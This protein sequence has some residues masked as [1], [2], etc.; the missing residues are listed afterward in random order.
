MDIT[1]GTALLTAELP[2]QISEAVSTDASTP[3]NQ[4]ILDAAKDSYKVHQAAV[5]ALTTA[6]VTDVN[7]TSLTDARNAL[8]ATNWAGSGISPT[9]VTPFFSGTAM[10]TALETVRQDTSIKAA[11]VGAFTGTGPGDGPEVVSF[12]ANLPLAEARAGLIVGLDIFRN[13]VNVEPGQN[14]QYGL[15]LRPVTDLHDSVLGLYINTT[16]GSTPVNLK[17]LMSQSLQPYAFVSST[18]ASVPL[19]VGVFAGST[20]QWQS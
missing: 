3:T 18:G 14:L 7:D 5:D 15:W 12:A 11:S 13:I 16:V 10:T 19:K 20:S 8:D 1:L 9:C 17:I 4:Q 2:P 6:L